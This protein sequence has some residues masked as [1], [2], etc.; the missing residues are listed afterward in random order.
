MSAEHKEALIRAFHRSLL[1][2]EN[3]ERINQARKQ[4]EKILGRTIPP[5]SS[6][7]KVVDEAM[8]AAV[9][10]VAPLLIQQCT[11]TYQAYDR[12]VDLL[13]RQPTLGVRSSTSVLQQAYSTPIPI[14]Y[15]AS[16]LAAITPDTTVYEPTA[17]NGAL[18]ITVDPTKAIANELNDDRLTELKH[19]GYS[20]LTQHNAT[21]Y[22]PQKQVDIMICNPP[23]GAVHDENGKIRRFEIPGNRRGTRQVDHAI[24]FK[25][26]E[27]IKDDGR[28][29]LILGGKLGDDEELRSNRYNSIESRGFFFSLYQH[30]NVT[31][32]FSIWGNLY[33]KQGAGF[34]I[35]VILIEG[36]GQSQRDLPAAE[37]PLI[38]KS[39][40]ALKERLPDELIQ[41][42]GLQPLL[43][44]LE[45]S[46]GGRSNPISGQTP[47]RDKEIDL[48]R[49]PTLDDAQ[50]SVDDSSLVGR[51]WRGSDSS[52]IADSAKLSECYRRKNRRRCTKTIRRRN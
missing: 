2:G 1:E 23:F 48:A 13:D 18:L 46:S 45:A 7:T 8:E 9:V 19:R 31:Q 6:M 10:R 5:G 49:L 3:Y 35:D 47:H 15:L 30:Y 29:V 16:T 43:I 24:A 38:Y 17:G 33:R 42:R 50:N 25:A 27:A 14:A 28:A 37:V 52:R 26:L 51:E 32:H 21:S 22:R 20:Q 44:D 41:H 36:R 34:P 4:A 11:T 39:F 12:L 40:D